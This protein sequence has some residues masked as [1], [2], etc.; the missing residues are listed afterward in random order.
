MIYQKAAGFDQ[1][2]FFA[3]LFTASPM[4]EL[5]DVK[6][7]EGLRNRHFDGSSLCELRPHREPQCPG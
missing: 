7:V 6:G 3:L 5:V 1:L 4:A 2:L